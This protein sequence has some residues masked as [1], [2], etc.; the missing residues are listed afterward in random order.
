MPV[1]VPSTRHVTVRVMASSS[2]SSTRTPASA[3]LSV[4]SG[5]GERSAITIDGGEFR[6]T[7]SAVDASPGPWGSDAVTVTIHRSSFAVSVAGTV[8]VSPAATPSRVQVN[9]CVTGSPS[10]SVPGTS[11]RATRSS[12][13]RGSAGAIDT[14]GAPGAAS[15]VTEAASEPTRPSA[16]VTVSVRT[17]AP[18][19]SPETSSTIRPLASGPA[20]DSGPSTSL[21]QRTVSVAGSW[22]GSS[23]RASSATAPGR[24]KAW[25][26]GDRM[27]TAGAVIAPTVTVALSLAVRP[28][29]SSTTS[30]ISWA[31]ATRSTTPLTKPSASGAASTTSGPDRSLSQRRTSA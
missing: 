9:V 27:V 6:I 13:V 8:S 10:G 1:G 7:T 26:A 19:L 14:A 21:D 23:T 16:S 12:T 17:C 18:R 4:T 31:P 11:T 24:T 22:S 30:V 3:T 15:T 20:D 2:G 28:W 5:C 29:V 25:S